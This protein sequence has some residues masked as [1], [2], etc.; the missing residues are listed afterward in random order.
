MSKKVGMYSEAW[1]KRKAKKSLA[2]PKAVQEP[3]QPSELEL[4]IRGLGFQVCDDGQI[5]DAATGEL[6]NDY[7]QRPHKPWF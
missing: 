7:L 5:R 2:Q 1:W 6:L 3:K 4:M